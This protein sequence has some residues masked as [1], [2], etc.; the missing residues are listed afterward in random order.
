[1]IKYTLICKNCQNLFD[2]WFASSQ[3]YEK[4]KK[5]NYINCIKCD[6]IKVEKSLMSPNIIRFKNN[7]LKNNSQKK[8]RIKM[9]KYQNFIKSNFRY[10]GK[11]FSHEARIIHYNKKNK[12]NGIYGQATSNEILELKEEGIETQIIPWSYKRDN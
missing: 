3:E 12:I 7:I 6:S 4:L 11:N 8:I 10:V 1:M 5:K 9:N 2:S